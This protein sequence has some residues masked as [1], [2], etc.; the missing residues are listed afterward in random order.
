LDKKTGN[1][2]EVSVCKTNTG[3]SAHIDEIHGVVA[4]GKNLDEIKNNMTE[5]LKLHVKGLKEDGEPL[6][7]FLYGKY[8][9]LFKMDV[10]S[11]LDYYDGVLTQ[12]ALARLTGINVK[13]LNHYA[14]GRSKPRPAQI[15]K[16]EK[17]LHKLGAELMLI[18]L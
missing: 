15:R 1:I 7:D 17:G 8:E 14:R 3:Y 2:V 16:I 5:A 4:T 12:S 11:L 9:L 6:P 13:Q 10:E 18:N